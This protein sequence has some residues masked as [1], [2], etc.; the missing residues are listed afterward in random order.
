MLKIII[1]ND[2]TANTPE[3]TAVDSEGKEFC[4]VGNYDFKVFINDKLVGKGRIEGHNRITGWGGLIACLDEAVN[5]D[6]F[7]RD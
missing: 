4:I 3:N 1:I 5:G 2:S 6:A 7:E